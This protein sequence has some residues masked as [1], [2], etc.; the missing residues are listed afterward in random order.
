[1]HHG[2]FGY[3]EFSI[4]KFSSTHQRKYLDHHW[5][6]QVRMALL[7]T[8]SAEKHRYYLS[9]S[10]LASMS[11]HPIIRGI[12]NGRKQQD[13]CIVWSSWR[14]H[15]RP[16]SPISLKKYQS[17]I[18][19]TVMPEQNSILTVSETVSKNINPYYHKDVKPAHWVDDTGT[20]FRNPW[21]SYRHHSFMNLLSVSKLRIH[22]KFRSLDSNGFLLFRMQLE[23]LCRSTHPWWTK[24]QGRLR[25]ASPFASLPGENHLR[26]SQG[27][28]H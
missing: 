1:M 24:T 5:V 21:E 7:L 20:S 11:K 2:T 12:P 4:L 22:P 9:S 10:L 27:I 25:N 19:T 13:F 18:Q 28:N 6:F 14:F 26:S 3:S 23:S 16:R 15:H 8:T 17:L